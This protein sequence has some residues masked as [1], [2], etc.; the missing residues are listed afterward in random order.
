MRLISICSLFVSLYELVPPYFSV[1]TSA[2]R[3]VAHLLLQLSDSFGNED[4]YRAIYAQLI[5]IEVCFLR[6]CVGARHEAT[7]KTAFQGGG[8]AWVAQD[9]LISMPALC[10]KRTFG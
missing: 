2:T 5:C 3:A 4:K 1:E 6:I 9:Y 7:A 10:E 8:K